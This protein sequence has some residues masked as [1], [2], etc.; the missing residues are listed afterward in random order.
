MT[1]KLGI[2]LVA[3]ALA[4]PAAPA[5]AGTYDVHACATS[6]GRFT[7]HAWT[8][9]A[10]GG[11]VGASCKASDGRPQLVVQASAN[12]LFDA[13]QHASLTF[14]APPGATIE[15]FALHRQ[16]YQFN[17]MDGAPSGRQMLYSLVTLGGTALEGGGHYDPAVTSALGSRYYNGGGAYD[18]G[19]ATLTRAS[20]ATLAG[21]R[22]TA[23]TLRL[24]IGCWTQPCAIETNGAGAVG[25]IFAA[26]FGATV[27]VRDA[28]APRV[29]RIYRRGLAAGGAV[30][31]TEPL[32]FDAADN[33]GIRQ[34]QLFDVGAQRVVATHT[35]H[36]DFSYAAPCPSLHA[37]HLS[38]RG[39]LGTRTLALRL[40]DA[41]GNVGSGPRFRVT[42]EGPLNGSPASAAARLVA[43]FAG[44]RGRRARIPA[45]R[46][47]RLRGRLTDRAGRPIAHAVLQLRTRFLRVGAHWR[48]VGAA[49][50]GADGRF[51]AGL[52]RGVARRVRVEYRL[53]RFAPA[54]VA[55]ARLTLAVPA[56]VT[57]AIAPHHVAPGGVIRLSGRLRGGHVPPSGKEV[58][59]QAFDTGHWRTFATVQAHRDGR[60]QTRYHFVRAA[61]GRT[62]RF[63]ARVRRDGAY[64]FVTGYSHEVRVAVV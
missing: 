9:Q 51:R 24:T 58:D 38:P 1:A 18:T 13:G 62:F 42:A 23:R 27:I 3:A 29:V 7:N 54:P 63:R 56:R 49:V 16:L 31:G 26:V 32:T 22:G 6:A 50:T 40:V 41:A 2:A 36:C 11:F 47:A 20:F 45:G 8:V 53:R 30:A 10:S 44:H 21:Y 35:Y 48:T 17:P 60:F 4:L 52:V 61:A 59:L 33:S 12:R 46:S 64:P 34:A 43:R 19:D 37:A 25:S 15:D 5:A 39:L 57:L 28:T 14:T 55:R